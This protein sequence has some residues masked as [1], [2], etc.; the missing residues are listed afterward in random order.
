MK[1]EDLYKDFLS[2]FADDQKIIETIAAENAVDEEDGMHIAFG[3]VVVPFIS[4]LIESNQADK[5]KR[6]FSF[7]EEMAAS[8]DPLI[9]EVLEFTVIEGIIAGGKDFASKCVKYMNPCTYASYE[10]ISRNFANP[11]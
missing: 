6:A 2:V 1:Y 3:M 5:I 10:I 9:S 4:K 7:F 11:E 8:E